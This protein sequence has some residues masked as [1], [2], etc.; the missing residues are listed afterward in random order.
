L[1]LF[2]AAAALPL[3]WCGIQVSRDRHFQERIDAI[4]KIGA[5][6][7]FGISDEPISFD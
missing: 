2:V 3:R 5:Q 6:V 4:E 7:G 1:L